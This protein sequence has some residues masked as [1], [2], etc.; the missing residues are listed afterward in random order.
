VRARCFVGSA[1]C[2]IPLTAPKQ[3]RSDSRVT[4]STIVGLASSTTN[5]A[6]PDASLQGP[7]ASLQTTDRVASGTACDSGAHAFR[8]LVGPNGLRRSAESD[9]GWRRRH[10]HMHRGRVGGR[11]SEGGGESTGMLEA[12][13]HRDGG[14]GGV[15]QTFLSSWRRCRVVA[16]SRMIGRRRAE[17]RGV[18]FWRPTWPISC[19]SGRGPC[20]QVFV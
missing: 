1:G 20:F 11:V 19:R 8:H 7:D 12:M 16:V 5:R 4:A 3:Y 9:P 17:A 6:G 2:R 10:R 14:L 18:V 13:L 15:R